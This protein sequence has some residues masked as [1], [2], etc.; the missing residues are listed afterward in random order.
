MTYKLRQRPLVALSI[1][2]IC[3]LCAVGLGLLIRQRIQSASTGLERVSLRLQWL[4]QAQFAGFY[5]AEA[6]GFYRDEGLD[7]DIQPGGQD[8]NAATLVA[9]GSNDFGIWT[10]DQVMLRS[11]RGFPFVQ[12]ASYLTA[13]WRHSWSVPRLI[14]SH[15][16]ISKEKPSECTTDTTPKRFT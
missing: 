16:R 4:H 7:V 2:F 14:L 11:P 5:V 10:A 6:K 1:V 12:S 9:A 13:V 8:F 3:I 15:R